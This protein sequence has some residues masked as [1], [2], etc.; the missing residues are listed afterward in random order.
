[1]QCFILFSVTRS[2]PGQ[3]VLGARQQ[4]NQITSYLDASM[5]YGSEP[6]LA[7]RLREGGGGG[8]L[9]L[10][11]PHPMSRPES[12]LLPLL[13]LTG[14]NPECRAADKQCFL[15]GDGR[16]NEQPGLTSFHTVMV[17][18]GGCYAILIQCRL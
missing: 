16:V 18:R 3:K 5:V 13:P 2:L 7:A 8:S 14:D 15:A 1:M 4:I 9:L 10:S 11:S 12:P 6:C 17:R